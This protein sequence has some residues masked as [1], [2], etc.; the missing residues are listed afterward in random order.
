MLV[1]SGMNC[2]LIVGIVR[3]KNPAHLSRTSLFSL[4]LS[5]MRVT[6]FPFPPLPLYINP[7]H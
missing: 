3:L 5:S 7:T 2:G 6:I 1:I 4:D